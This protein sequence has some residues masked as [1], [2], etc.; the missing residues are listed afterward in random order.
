MSASAAAVLFSGRIVVGAREV[1]LGIVGLLLHE[2]VQ[3]F[4]GVS[5]LPAEDQ[6]VGHVQVRGVLIGLDFDGFRQLLIGGSAIARASWPPAP[7]CNGRRRSAHRPGWR[8]E[9]ESPLPGTGPCRNSAGRSPDTSA[10]GRSDPANNP[11]ST[12]SNKGRD[13][14]V[15]SRTANPEILAIRISLTAFTSRKLGLISALL[16]KGT[17]FTDSHESYCRSVADG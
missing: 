10:C 3:M 5:E 13:R 6:Q 4:L 7:A 2:Q 12:A 17:L 8:S 9:T 14:I 11:V 1:D 16:H 15:K